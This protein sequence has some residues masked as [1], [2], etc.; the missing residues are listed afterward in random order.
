MGGSGRRWAAVGGG[1]RRW[2]AAGG[3]GRRWA[4]VGGGG[5]RWAAVGG[6]GFA[7][8]GLPGLP[9][10][11]HRDPGSAGSGQCSWAMGARRRAG[12][13]G[14]GGA[15][16]VEGEPELLRDEGRPSED[17]DILQVAAAPVAE[18]G[19]LDGAHIEHA[20][21]L[22]EHQRRE[23]LTRDVVCSRGGG[24]L[25]C[26]CVCVCVCVWCACACACACVRMCGVVCVC[27]VC[28]AC[29]ACAACARWR[30]G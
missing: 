29:A 18:A 9:D 17:G 21:H 25:L 5:R 23:R 28:V 10:R 22:V 27:V 2:A 7:L 12:W 1:G 24:G 14:C 8:P 19:G 11:P 13:L 30:L 20:T 16:L 3:S 4:A 6:G 15:H 26:V